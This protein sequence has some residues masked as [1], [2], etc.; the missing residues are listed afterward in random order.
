MWEG[1]TQPQIIDISWYRS[2][3]MCTYGNETRNNITDNILEGDQVDKSLKIVLIVL[4]AVVNH[5]LLGMVSKFTLSK[6]PGKRLVKNLNPVCLRFSLLRHC[7]G[8]FWYTQ[9]FHNHVSFCQLCLLLW[10]SCQNHF[11]SLVL[12]TIFILIEL[13]KNFL[14]FAVSI[15]NVSIIIQVSFI[16]NLEWVQNYEDQVI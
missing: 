8:Y 6:P 10:F 4:Y 3:K 13:M 7:L 14:H 12:W 15:F 5:S 1:E 2:E 16:L 9:L 11:W